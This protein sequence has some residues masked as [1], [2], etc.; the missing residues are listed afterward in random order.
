MKKILLLIIF[1]CSISL[2]SQENKPT[3]YYFIRHSEKVLKASEQN[4]DLTKKGRKRA[5]YWSEVFNHVKFDMVFSTNFKR[6]IATASPT[7]KRKGLKIQLYEPKKLLSKD[8][9]EKTKG[10]TI[11]I[12]GH[13]NT[14]PGYVNKL[15]NKKKYF[16]IN[17]SNYSNLYIVTLTKN[18]TTDILLKINH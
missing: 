11:L 18:T 17:E 12:V 3:T 10:K 4:P 6:T 8:F 15:L 7:A 1:I 9:I 2:Y 14:I 16:D 5:I 13:S